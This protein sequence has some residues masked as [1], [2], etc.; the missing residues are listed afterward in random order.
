MWRRPTRLALSNIRRTVD[1]A[2]RAPPTCAP[3]TP[4]AV[5]QLDQQNLIDG[6]IL[7]QGIGLYSDINGAPNGGNH[8]SAQVFTVGVT[9]RLTRVRVPL[10]NLGDANGPVTMEILGTVG[11]APDDAQKLG[12]VTV[13]VPAA[14]V[15]TNANPETWVVFDFGAQQINITAGQQRAFA[16]R[17]TST[18]GIIYQPEATS[19]YAAGQGFRRNRLVTAAWTPRTDD[20]G[21]QVFV[22]GR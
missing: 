20:Y 10:H 6:Q 4:P 8:Q 15:V 18:A 13:P 16:L 5:E 11:G 17:S 14:G 9:G 21:F 12:E 22:L 2:A 19:N 1:S 7:G 3:P